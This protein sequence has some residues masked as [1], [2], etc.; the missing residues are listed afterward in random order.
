MLLLK[1]RW[2][3]GNLTFFIPPRLNMKKVHLTSS[4][5]KRVLLW[6]FLYFSGLR[7]LNWMKNNPLGVFFR[8]FRLSKHENTNEHVLV[9]AHKI[10]ESVTL[11]RI[12]LSP[13]QACQK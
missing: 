10:H 8:I 12:I 6:F 7:R 4:E 2:V 11:S 1:E 5:A 9:Q 3:G 13:L